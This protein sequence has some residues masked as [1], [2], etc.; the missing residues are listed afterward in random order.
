ML[1]YVNNK[2]YFPTLVDL[3][4]CQ[5]PGLSFSFKMNYFEADCKMGSLEEAEHFFPQTEEMLSVVKPRKC[6]LEF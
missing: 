2:I 6:D 4:V 1:V 3:T 5:L